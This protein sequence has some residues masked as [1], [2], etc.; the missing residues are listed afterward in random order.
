MAT[1]PLD[2]RHLEG[3]LQFRHPDVGAVVG[4]A[5]GVEIWGCLPAADS[6][7]SSRSSSSRSQHRSS[8]VARHHQQHRDHKILVHRTVGAVIGLRKP[9][10]L[11]PPL[12]L[13]RFPH[14]GRVL[15]LFDDFRRSEIRCWL[16][17]TWWCVYRDVG[18]LNSEDLTGENN[19]HL[20]LQLMASKG[21]DALC[22][23]L[24]LCM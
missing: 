24:A 19:V 3:R 15:Y 14:Q 2:Q 16:S 13:L 5:A 7:F 12:F 8:L 6:F 17:G 23:A 10:L 11:P 4:A 21:I 20:E 1:R 18:S 9:A 22:R